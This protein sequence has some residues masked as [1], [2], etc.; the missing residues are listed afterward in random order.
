M[1]PHRQTDGMGAQS[2]A[3]ARQTP[4]RREGRQEQAHDPVGRL[5]WVQLSIPVGT[6]DLPHG[7]MMP[8]CTAPCLVAHPFP[9]TALHEGACRC[10]P[11]PAQP[12]QATIGVICRVLD[13]LGISPPCPKEGAQCTPWMPVLVGARQATPLQPK[14]QPDMVPADFRSHTLQA[15]ACHHALA[16]LALLLLN[17][18]HAISRPPPKATARSTTP[19]GLAVDSTGSTTCC[20]WDGRTETIAKRCR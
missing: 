19:Y 1:R 11:H 5:V 7:G 16:T 2:A 3:H 14:D 20:G 13:A 15:P 4:G 8:P 18:D 6:S 9:Q 17:D 10:A 12:A